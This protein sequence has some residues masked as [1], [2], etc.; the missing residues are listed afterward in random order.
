[1]M[2]TKF[3]KN[4]DVMVH[5]KHILPKRW[6]IKPASGERLRNGEKVTNFEKS[7]GN[8]LRYYLNSAFFV[9]VLVFSDYRLHFLVYFIGNANEYYMEGGNNIFFCIFYYLKT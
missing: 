3:N 2:K 7:E 1:M 5:L 9:L 6:D 4:F 8:T